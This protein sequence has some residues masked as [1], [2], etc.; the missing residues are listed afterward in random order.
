MSEA[1]ATRRPESESRWWGLVK[2]IA[3]VTTATQLLLCLLSWLP[4]VEAA[5]PKQLPVDSL[6][7]QELRR[8]DQSQVLA[9]QEAR[10]Q[11]A[12]EL[13][14]EL[15]Q[16]RSMFEGYRER[17]QAIESYARTILTAVGFFAALLSFGVWK[18]LDEQ[19]SLAKHLLE[20]QLK[21]SEIK[22]DNSLKQAQE[23][24]EE[25]RRE[26]PMFNR[27]RS[28]YADILLELKAE[29]TSIVAQ[30]DIYQKLTPERR[31]SIL[32]YEEVIKGTLPFHTADNRDELSEVFRL[33]G[34][35]Y[36]SRYAHRCQG[37]FKKDTPFVASLDDP[38]IA[39]AIFYFD[40]SVQLNPANNLAYAHGGHFT[41]YISDERLAVRCQSYLQKAVSREPNKQRSFVNLAQLEMLFFQNFERGIDLMNQAVEGREW[42]QPG[43]SI[44][45][46]VV[47]YVRATAYARKAKTMPNLPERKRFL[48]LALDDLEFA[49]RESDAWI[50]GQFFDGDYQSLPDCSDAFSLLDGDVETRRRLEAATMLLRASPPDAEST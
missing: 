6:N 40:R 30:D 31:Q 19:R 33:L 41:F 7:K 16:Q 28:A 13:R 37:T 34:I 48:N 20:E 14:S 29:C 38:D 26:F 8:T 27:V 23:L 39:R 5:K 47:R 32:F 22:A 2:V 4:Y 21:Q 3:I 43:S 9:V 12:A 44:K 17:V 35:I 46:A 50:R 36:G 25:I 49:A 11:L 45:P 10:T 18:A 24:R 1:I 15:E 42:E